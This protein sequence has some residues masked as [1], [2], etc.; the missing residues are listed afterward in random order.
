MFF[1]N[2]S[3]CLKPLRQTALCLALAALAV[4]CASVSEQPDIAPATA[5]G[6]FHES[7]EL[8]GRFSASYLKDGREEAIHGGFHWLQNEKNT[9]ITLLSPLGQTMANIDVTSTSSTLTA[10]GQNPRT[11]ANPDA[12]AVAS[13]GWPLPVSGLRQWLQGRAL[14]TQGHRFIASPVHK[15]VSTQ[16]GWHLHYPAWTEAGTPKRID[17]ERN[18]DGVNLTLRFV[19]DTWQPRGN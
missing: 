4:G 6:T 12:L 14:D 3:S 16:D 7:I 10:S 5:S 15:D 2:L 18:A 9:S 13:L 11:A 17:L 8:S 19:I 1:N